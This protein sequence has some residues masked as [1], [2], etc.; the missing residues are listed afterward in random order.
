[1]AYFIVDT[2]Y[3]QCFEIFF[4]D[5]LGYPNFYRMTELLN[6]EPL[7]RPLTLLVPYPS[8]APTII[9]RLSEHAQQLGIKCMPFG[10]E[11]E[12]PF[13]FDECG[14]LLLPMHFKEALCFAVNEFLRINTISGAA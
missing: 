1:M 12:T 5:E 6:D 11:L 8:K 4:K 13:V 2:P 14:Q 10:Q 9:Q 7:Y 3:E